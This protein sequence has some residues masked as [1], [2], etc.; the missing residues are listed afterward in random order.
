MPKTAQEYSQQI[1]D[2]LKVLLPDLSADPL[3]PERKI[4]D[5]VSEI[6]AEGSV[7]PYILNYQYDIDTKVGTDLDKFVALFGFARQ[8]GRRA[9][10]LVTFSRAS[11]ANA[12][13]VVPSGTVVMKPATSVS[14]SVSFVTTAVAILP[15]GGT[16]VEVPIEAADEGVVGN[17]PAGTI[18]QITG[19]SIT[20]V[21]EV[22]NENATTG[23]TAA[24]TDAELRVRFKNT[25][26]RNVAGTQ[27]QFL[28][29]AIA[30]RFASKANV[31]GPISR[32]V[33]YLQIE[34]DL[35]INSII[36]YSKYTYP[37]DYYLTN[38]DISNE[39]F[40]QPTF[41]YNFVP[42]VPPSINVINTTNLPVG[43]VV[44]LEHAYCSINSRNNPAVGQSNYVD[45]YVSGANAETSVETV[46]FPASTRAF[47]SAGSGGPYDITGFVRLATGQQP[48]PGNRLQELLWQPVY[49]LP[50][51]ITINGTDYFE[52]V[53]YWQIKDNTTYK[54]SKRAR[55]GIEWDASVISQVAAG[56][57]YTISYDFNKLAIILNELMDRHKQ[58]TTDVLV[59]AATN[60]YFNIN[61]IVMYTAGFARSSV[62]SALNS[63]IASF[64]NSQQFGALLQLSDILDVAHSVPGVDNVR[65]A[66]PSDGIA[67]GIQEVAADGVSILGPP[68]ISDFAL[69]DSDLPVLNQVITN[70]RSQN[71]W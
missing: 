43:S 41:D 20:S 70:Q 28:A 15:A 6:L 18:I 67:Y 13:I 36:P 58:I 59:H 62:D 5:T 1:R 55:D 29:L 44:L 4:I 46:L 24:E 50:S 31:I 23:G 21:S 16:F 47:V 69:Q 27:D 66:L 40:Y 9:T 68:Y 65:L 64:M 39:T 57:S 49:N 26:F 33:E 52:N 60:R 7:E 22:F 14:G 35:S 32:F 54:G 42:N 48:N 45:V 25:I 71:T 2:Q 53:H 34:S 56:T 63:S 19:G 3:T 38:G 30:T 10:G 11:V 51:V 8:G 37:F 17:V 61:L 12:D